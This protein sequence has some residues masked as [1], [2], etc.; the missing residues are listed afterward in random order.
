AEGSVNE[1]DPTLGQLF[2]TVFSNPVVWITA[3][4]YAC[5]G[6]VRQGVDQWFPKYVKAQFGIEMKSA[7]F[8]ILVFGIPLVAT[9]GS[10]ASGYV[11]DVF[12]KG[13]RAPVAA[14]LYLAET[15]IILLAAR[16]VTANTVVP[17]LIL[18]AFTA[19]ATHS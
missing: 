10:L 5:T 16:F 6:V 4:A 1:P 2:W 15:C 7:Y 18:I 3:F 11:S 8:L 17:F 14:A 9:L 19:N 13:K 12:F